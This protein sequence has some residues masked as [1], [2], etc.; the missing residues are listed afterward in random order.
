M[1]E[2][3][4]GSPIPPVYT[5]HTSRLLVFY[6]LFL[7]L[8]LHGS[9]TRKFVTVLVTSTVSYAMLGLDEIS[10]VLEQPFGLMPLHQLSRNICLIL[11]IPLLISHHHLESQ[12][13]LD[14]LSMKINLNHHTG[15]LLYH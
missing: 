3:L 8:A 4:R 1:C 14:I 6:L 7:P 13:N 12:K 2:R 15:R 11:Q 10:H 9:E 5:S